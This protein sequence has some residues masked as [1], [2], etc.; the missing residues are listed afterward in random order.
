MTEIMLSNAPASWRIARLGELFAERKEKVSDKDYPAL[1]VTKN[2]VVPQLETAAK[3]DDGDNRKCVR[4]GDFVINSRSDRK[5]S[6]GLSMLDG[7][8]S[9]INIVLEPRRIEKR[10]AHYLLRCGAFQEEFYRWGHGIVADLWTTRYFDMKNIQVAVPDRDAQKAIAD[11]LDRETDRVD[12]LIEKKKRQTQLLNEKLDG[13]IAKVLSSGLSQGAA[14]RF[15]SLAWAP[16]IP[17]HWQI[18]RLRRLFASAEYG[19]SEELSDAGAIAVLRMGNIQYGEI[20]RSSLAFVDSVHPLMTLRHEDLLF[21]RTNSRDLVGKVGLFR[22]MDGARFS[23]ASY[24][25]RLRAS[26]LVQPEFLNILLNASPV[27]A[28]ARGL[29]IP[30]IS[31]SNLNPSRYGTIIVPLPP[32]AEQKQ[33]QGYVNDIKRRIQSA[34]KN[35][36]DSTRLLREHRS[37]FMTAAVTGQIDLVSWSKTGETDRR[38]DAIQ[39]SCA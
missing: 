6:A 3:T 15:T 2:G 7:S 9:L 22:G 5:G 36:H 13:L 11:F 24:L 18:V 32:I 4:I 14:T 23:F 19:I 39:E 29:A 21:N 28:E 31:Q 33:I 17:R 26:P 1:S 20:D 8:V 12:Q 38:L 25:V 10:F 27:L 16:S 35:L 30:S 34:I 37:V